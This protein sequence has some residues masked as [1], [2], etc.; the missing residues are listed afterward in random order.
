MFCYKIPQKF[1]ETSK[2]WEASWYHILTGI[3]NMSETARQIMNHWFH[4][5]KGAGWSTD[6]TCQNSIWWDFPIFRR[7]R[8]CICYNIPQRSAE[9]S[10]NWKASWHHILTGRTD[11]SE[12]LCQMLNHWFDTYKGAGWSTDCTC[13]NSIWR[14]LPICSRFSKCFC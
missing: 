13:E 10:E 7:F 2:N 11:K 5:Y 9:T 4:T 1:A 3:I 8:K 14:D 6:C 12:T